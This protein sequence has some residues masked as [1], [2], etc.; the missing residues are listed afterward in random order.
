M[1]DPIPRRGPAP[2]AVQATR[3]ILLAPQRFFA[4]RAIRKLME[5]ASDDLTEASQM[6]ETVR[7]RADEVRTAETAGVV[8]GVVRPVTYAYDDYKARLDDRV[9]RL[10]RLSRSGTPSGWDA[11]FNA[12]LVAGE[13]R[14][15][16]EKA[17]RALRDLTALE[18]ARARNR[19]GQGASPLYRDVERRLAAAKDDRRT[20][21]DAPTEVR[22]AARLSEDHARENYRHLL[23]EVE[24][25]TARAEKAVD[26]AW[27]GFMGAVGRRE[28]ALGSALLAWG[29]GEMSDAD[30]RRVLADDR[31]TAASSQAELQRK[32]SEAMDSARPAWLFEMDGPHVNPATH[33]TQPRTAPT[34]V[35]PALHD[36][37]QRTPTRT[38]GRTTVKPA[39]RRPFTRRGKGPRVR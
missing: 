26:T 17:E 23:P 12:L 29:R 10:R 1:A 21:F 19:E 36:Q 14:D 2:R 35:P 7:A 30:V 24:S 22:R 16:G 11:D 13:G 39:A 31:A 8:G 9:R 15:F 18:N 37:T 38:T 6:F 28:A 4:R 5:K 32:I 25:S 20:A 34:D 3:R 33:G 27:S